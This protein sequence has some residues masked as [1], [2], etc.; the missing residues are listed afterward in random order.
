M[1][2]GGQPG[3]RGLLSESVQLS[4][5]QPALEK[6]TGVDAGGGVA[7]EEDLV[8]AATVIGPPEEVVEADLDEGGAGRIA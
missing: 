1:W 4:C 3:A 7:L 6:G 8:A 2:I 5:G